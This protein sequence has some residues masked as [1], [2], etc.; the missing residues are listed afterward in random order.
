MKIGHALTIMLLIAGAARAD[1]LQRRSYLGVQ[2][3]LE[4][5]TGPGLLVTAVDRDSTA[6]NA[7]LRPGDRLTSVGS[8]GT[9]VSYPPLR[10]EL[11]RTAV[12]TRIALRW[13]RNANTVFRAAP[14]MGPLPAERVPGSR[15]RYGAVDAAGNA[16]RLIVT[17]P[18]NVDDDTRLVFFLP[19]AGCESLDFWAATENP[20]KRLI[21]GWAAAG[22]ATVR[23]EKRGVGDSEGASCA[24]LDFTEEH[25]GY[26]AALEHL[27]AL[28]YGGRVLLFGHGVGGL[29]ASE[30]ATNAV[31]G[32]MVYGATVDTAGD[33]GR[34]EAYAVQLAAY[35]PERRWRQVWQPVLA[36]HG[37]Y[38]RLAARDDQ[39]RIARLTG[40]RFQSLPR[41]GH[42]L[43]RYDSTDD[44]AIACG[45]GTFDPS[46]IDATLTWIR[47]LAGR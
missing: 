7:G 24:A 29:M 16:L 11:A 41:L 2:F 34:S 32:I 21:D 38:D 25:L 31:A 47:T 27:S 5:R 36:L 30:L 43:L 10:E 15:V 14:P 1:E 46:L 4:D 28:G 17:E 42:D 20:V 9:L 13:Y 6:A 37:A 26:L 40:G 8:I 12:G 19:D 3:D 35:D 18:E 39:E 23:L 22:F 44:A 33:A 45:T